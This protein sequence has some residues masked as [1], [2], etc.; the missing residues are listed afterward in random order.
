MPDD[1]THQWRASGVKVKQRNILTLILHTVYFCRRQ[2]IC[3][4][5]MAKI[6]ANI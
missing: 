3:Y 2:R 4:D 5:E 1:F 6:K